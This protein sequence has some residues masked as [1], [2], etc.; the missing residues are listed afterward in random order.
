VG[1][2]DYQLVAG[3]RRL[4]AA[5]LAGLSK[6][7]A[8]VRDYDD[9]QLM[10]L[11]I[12]E[13]IQRENLNPIDEAKAYHALIE[14]VGLTHDQV[15]ERVGKQRSSIT[16]SL[17]LLTLPPEIM[18]MVSRGT[19]SAGHARALLGLESAGDQLATGKYVVWT[20]R[21]GLPMPMV[22]RL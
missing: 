17:R 10:E 8:I 18:D 3:E 1:S 4:R 12:I 9:R 11:S 22:A 19:L 14:R 5:Q 2:D 6:I 21:V 13:N 15:S 20:M 16:N 7:P